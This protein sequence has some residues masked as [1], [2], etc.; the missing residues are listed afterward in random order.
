M[1]YLSAVVGAVASLLGLI[2]YGLVVVGRVPLAGDL[3]DLK[4]RDQIF[5]ALL[6]TAALSII[7]S[8][9]SNTNPSD[10]SYDIV[11]GATF[12]FFLANGFDGI[13]C[14]LLE[15]DSNQKVSVWDQVGFS[16]ICQNRRP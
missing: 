1:K 13:V 12:L 11:I 4:N 3:V 5:H 8:L 9:R 15:E 10:R 16:D 6:V 2:L 14:L 7:L